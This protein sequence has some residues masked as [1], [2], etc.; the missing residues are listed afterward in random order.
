MQVRF[1]QFRQALVQA[2][3]PESTVPLTEEL[4][5]RF[6]EESRTQAE[7]TVDLEDE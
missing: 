2:G 1:I 7:T 5:S 6:E 4:R 3:I